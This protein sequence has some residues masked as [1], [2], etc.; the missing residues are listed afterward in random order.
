MRGCAPM[1]QGMNGGLRGFLPRL[2][3]TQTVCDTATTTRPSGRPRVTPCPLTP[4][5]LLAP[6]PTRPQGHGHPVTALAFPPDGSPTLATGSEDCRLRLWST[7]SG[8]LTATLTGHMATVACAAFS[9]DCRTIA[10]GCEQGAIRL[11]N[12]ATGKGAAALNGHGGTV[13]RVAF[14]PDGRLL[15]SGGEDLTVRLWDAGSGKQLA[16][17]KGHKERVVSLAFGA[18]GRVLCSGS[19]GEGVA[20]SV[21]AWDAGS[22]Q[23]LYALHAAHMAGDAEPAPGTVCTAVSALEH[24]PH[25]TL[26]SEAG[27]GAKKPGTGQGAGAGAGGQQVTEAGGGR[28][29][30]RQVPVFT[31]FAAPVC[32]AVHGQRFAMAFGSHVYFYSY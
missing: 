6:A 30:L 17:M 15:A 2:P 26:V 4:N 13:L 14:S 29:R 27:V 25:L 9:P 18:S 7:A 1:G 19:R 21:F 12:A 23:Q 3:L 10:S 28:L 8:Q 11:W 5:P 16:V 24:A 32:V 22:G 31:S 20:G